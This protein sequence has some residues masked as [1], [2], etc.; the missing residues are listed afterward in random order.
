MYCVLVS[1]LLHVLDKVTYCDT[2]VGVLR[3]AKERPSADIL[4]LSV[5]Q[6]SCFPGNS[7]GLYTYMKQQN[8]DDFY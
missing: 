1:Q 4:E 8:L 3:G 2:C 7:A 6:V 5:L